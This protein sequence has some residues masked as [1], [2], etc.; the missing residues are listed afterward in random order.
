MSSA[1]PALIQRGQRS[2]KDP[3]ILQNTI[4]IFFF[5]CKLW[6]PK[7]SRLVFHNPSLYIS[8][9]CL[10]P[11][12]KHPKATPCGAA[13]PAPNPQIPRSCCHPTEPACLQQAPFCQS[14]PDLPQTEVVGL[15]WKWRITIFLS[16]QGELS[17]QGFFPPKLSKH[18]G[19]LKASP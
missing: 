13:G 19:S 5:L 8:Q 11:L 1:F 16:L 18:M 9:R 14:E 10:I 4:K 15:S 2:E 7:R 3:Q 12:P 6:Q 17:L